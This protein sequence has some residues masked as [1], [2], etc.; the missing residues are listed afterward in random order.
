MKAITGQASLTNNQGPSP[1]TLDTVDRIVD[2]LNAIAAADEKT[3]SAAAAAATSTNTVARTE[4]KA[5]ATKA[6]TGTA[7]K[8]A[9]VTP[10]PGT[11]DA[12]ATSASKEATAEPKK[13]DQADKQSDSV[14]VVQRVRNNLLIT[15]KRTTVLKIKRL[16]TLLDAPWPQVQLDVLA[17]QVSGCP[18][19]VAERTQA[20]RDH[21]NKA[22]RAIRK[23]EK[24]V[25]E[26]V[27]I[28]NDQKQ[29]YRTDD[30]FCTLRDK[31]G[32]DPDPHREMTLTE[33]LVFLCLSDINIMS[34]L[35]MK[36]AE[37]LGSVDE[38]FRKNQWEE[39]N[40]V[41]QDDV[42]CYRNTVAQFA[43]D[44]RIFKND[45]SVLKVTDACEELQQ[46]SAAAD[47]LLQRVMDHYTTMVRTNLAAMMLHS[48]RGTEGVSLAGQCRIV[49][50]S[51][52][53]SGLIPT[54]SSWAETTR[55]KPLSG[56][57]MSTLMTTV[58]KSLA[59]NGMDPAVLG[60]ALKLL[61]QPEPVYTR[62][63]PGIELHVRPTVLPS[64]AEARLQ[65]YARF[66]VKT[67]PPDK[68]KVTGSW[69]MPPAPAVE[70][71]EMATDAHIGVF[72]L[73]DISS[74]EITTSHP[75]SPFCIPIIGKIP[76]LGP[77]FQIPR[78][79]KEVKH[80]SVILVNAVII[81]RAVNLIRDY[82]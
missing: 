64:A 20:I 56:E 26:T 24:A 48:L 78:A 27:R 77:A 80:A 38:K 8:S 41:T 39:L 53:E 42:G 45:E 22:K 2:A 12:T 72:D 3:A 50:T 37:H 1:A 17:F 59:T 46:S 66:G 4:S 49:V 32:F 34:V 65:I 81:P 21:I 18:D 51:S 68:T 74:F 15:G 9:S 36:L 30:M 60:P 79:N 67:E 25:C 43:N 82:P 44:W 63:A 71:H 10:Q 7:A 23:A 33:A 75:Q 11:K 13:E 58:I 69:V 40:E 16:L 5:P 28:W 54:V 6:A 61:E 31:C 47:K 73:F 62:V 57:E 70:S 52:L 55:L 29:L 19:Q 14:K 35:R 76:W